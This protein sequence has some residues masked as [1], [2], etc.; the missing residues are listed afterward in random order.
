MRGWVV[1]MVITV[2]VASL[3]SAARTPGQRCALAKLK[4]AARRTDAELRCAEKALA[5]GGTIDAG[6]MAGSGKAFD[7]A[8]RKAEAK[9]GCA[10][11]A[12]AAIVAALVDGYVN[13]LTAALPPVPSTSTTTS[14]VTTTTSTSTTTTLT[15]CGGVFPVCTGSCPEGQTCSAL[16]MPAFPCVCS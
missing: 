2:L 6:C 14:S 10:P 3:A 1:V 5:A 15:P 13:D 12:D 7:A 9:G 16:P 8:F 11:T 4:A